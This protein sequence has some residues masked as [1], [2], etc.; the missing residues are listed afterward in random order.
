[1]EEK[2]GYISHP[3]R[4]VGELLDAL[5]GV[6]RDAPVVVWT[7]G[8][9][10]QGEHPVR[11]TDIR[12]DGDKLSTVHLGLRQRTYATRARKAKE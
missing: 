2:T 10:E 5:I 6:S 8:N 11:I 1:M 3:V 7:M 4:T 9:A 12:V